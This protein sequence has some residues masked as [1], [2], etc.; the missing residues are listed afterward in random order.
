MRAVGGGGR[1][2]RAGRG[3][4]TPP[5][6]RGPGAGREAGTMVRKLRRRGEYGAETETTGRGRPRPARAGGG[7]MR[8]SRR[9]LVRDG[10]IAA[11]RGGARSQFSTHTRARVSVLAPCSRAG[12]AAPLADPG[13][14][15]RLGSLLLRIRGCGRAARVAPAG[16]PGRRSS[17]GRKQI[18]QNS[19]RASA[20]REFWLPAANPSRHPSVPPPADTP[21]ARRRPAPAAGSSFHPHP[22]GNRPRAGYSSSPSAP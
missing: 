1:S 11:G 17:A 20:R 3:E 6:G 21:P 10:T 13:V 16:L 2:G 7:S 19:R 22:P 8:E 9:W 5:V 12:R 18:R 15:A 4:G 14:A